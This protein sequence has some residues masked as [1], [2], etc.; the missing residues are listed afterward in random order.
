MLQDQRVDVEG[1]SVEGLR[2]EYDEE[3]RAVIESVGRDTVV[4]E[5]E[6]DPD[7][8]AALADGESTSIALPD[9]AAILA[10]GE[11]YPDAE[12]IET[13][14]CEHLLLGMSMAVLDVDSLA[15]ELSLDLSA[16]EIQQKLERR[17]PM[18]LD[19]FVAIEYVIADRQV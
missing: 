17:A 19:E 7:T 2:A 4:A 10:L 8:V 3:L 12:T 5:T 16:K 11:A 18:T 15:G 13:M 9:A 14:A 1:L 6:V